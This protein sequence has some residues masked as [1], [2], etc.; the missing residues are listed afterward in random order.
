[1]DRAP[2]APALS[3]GDERLTYGE[4]DRRANRLARHLQASGVRPGDRV[5]L[6][7]ERSAEMVVAIL[8]V[9]KAG[10]AYVPLDPA[11]PAERLAFTLEDSGASLLV[12]L[13]RPAG[14]ARPH[15]PPRRRAGRDRAPR[16]RAPGD[17]RSIR[18]SRPT[19]STPP[20]RPAGRRAWW[21]RT[22]TSTACSRRPTP[23]FGFGADDVWTLFHSYAF[24]F[25]VWELWGALLHGG[26][27]VVVPYW[28][29]RSPEDFY[30]LLATSGSPC[31]TRP[32]RPSASSSGR[33]RPRSTA[34]AG[35]RPALG[36]LRRRGAGA[37]EPRPLVRPPRRRAAAAGQ[38]VRHHRDHRARHLPAGAGGGPRRAGSLIGQPIPDLAVHLLDRQPAAGA[39]RRPRRDPR[40]RR[41]ARPRLPRP[42]GPHRRALRPRSLRAA[43]RARASTARATWPA[44]CRTAIWSTSAAIDQQVKIRGFRIE[45]GEI[46]AALAAQPG[47]REAVV[48]AREDGRRRAPP[49]RLRGR[50]R[51]CRPIAAGLRARPGRAAAGLH[52]PRGL[53]LLDALPL[54]ENGKVDRRAL[55]RAG[56]RRTAPA[57]ERRGAAH[58]L[59]RF[60]AGQFREVLGLPAGARDRRSTRTSST[61]AAPR[62]PA[63]SSSTACRRRWGRSSTW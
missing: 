23:W 52:A 36:D 41:R 32:R 12:D 28:V 59:E 53:R 29:S 2:E 20:A 27:L 44:A 61:S 46:E 13:G 10:A 49:G 15:G 14:G 42:A 8:A 48:L 43:A 45:L 54:T 60:L 33:R 57:Q 18:T 11:Y 5:A 62:S 26:R 34:R 9:L 51:R 21:S 30:R 47:V 40:R 4:L 24:D 25:S 56:G 55:P 7:L 63:P 19:S 1:M 22:P 38:H 16:R 50:R 35:P 6:L 39:G 17:R 3:V 31:S 37:G 58:P